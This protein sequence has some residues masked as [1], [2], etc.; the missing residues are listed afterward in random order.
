MTTVPIKEV[1]CKGCTECCQWGHHPDAPIV[2]TLAESETFK[3]KKVT[4]PITE[5]SHYSLQT[6]E[7]GDC[8]YLKRGKGCTV[9]PNSPQGCRKFTCLDVVRESESLNDV[10]VNTLIAGIKIKYSLPRGDDSE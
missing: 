6:A 3:S 1:N 10:Y 2:I 9:W 4:N 7:N 8:I 5:K